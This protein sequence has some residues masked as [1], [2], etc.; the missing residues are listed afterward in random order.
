MALRAV[1]GA[2]TVQ[3][4]VFDG[5]AAD[6][7]RRAFA[8]VDA[9]V[10]LVLAFFAVA[11]DEVANRRA[12]VFQSFLEDGDDGFMETDRF[13]FRHIVAVAHRPDTRPEQG[14]I[15][16]DI[17][18]AGHFRLVQEERLHRPVAAL[19][20]VIEPVRREVRTDGVRSQVVIAFDAC[21]PLRRH[22]PQAAQGADIAVEEAPFAE[23]KNKM[24]GPAS[25]R[26]ASL[27]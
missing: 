8:A 14:F 11:A 2:A 7:T 13:F 27:M 15:D 12:A 6:R 25:T 17:A 1:V 26:S 19:E 20:E 3:F 10:V 22:E 21:R 18:Q 9:E 4:C 5:R 16:V 23:R 24:N